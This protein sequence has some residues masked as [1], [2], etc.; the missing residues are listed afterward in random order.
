MKIK[1]SYLPEEAGEAEQLVGLLR[2]LYPW[3]KICASDRHPPHRQ[4]YLTVKAKKDG[5][6]P[7]NTAVQ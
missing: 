4:V 3:A 5:C 7:V 2:Q 6:N 1:V